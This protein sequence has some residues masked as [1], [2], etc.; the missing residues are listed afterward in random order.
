VD[1]AVLCSGLRKH[2]VPVIC[3]AMYAL[4]VPEQVLPSA[5]RPLL[6]EVR[7]VGEAFTVL[8]QAIGPMSW[9]EGIP[10]IKP[11]LQIFEELTPDSVLVS[12]NPGSPVGH[13][14]EL[15][16]NAAQSKG[17]QGVVLSGNL[18]DTEGLRSI[19]F[20]AFYSD[21][22][23]TN[24]IGRWEMAAKQIPVV[25]GDVQIVPGDIVVADFDGIVI[26]PRADAER[27]L[28]EAS[29]ID[30]AEA[31]VRQETAAGVAPTAAFDK[32][33]HI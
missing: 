1:L 32:H 4:G 29:S 7:V 28:L 21:L 18:R 6:P 19:S 13:F 23:P 11:Y 5:L 14:G 15:T 10:R 8:G 24:A 22:S 27:V 2:P 26:I 33:G 20:Q 3:D 17:C 9:E 30:D 31:L 16:A 25:I 12:V